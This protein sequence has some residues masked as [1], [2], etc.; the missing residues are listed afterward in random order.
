MDLIKVG[1]LRECMRV[2]K[3]NV[4]D[5]VVSKGRQ[6]GDGSAFLSSSMSS[7]ADKE[8]GVLAGET[9][10]RP[11]LTSLIPECLSGYSIR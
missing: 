8:T 9:S 4:D 1:E 7:S 2:A 6:C 10:R 11:E 3:G 5:A